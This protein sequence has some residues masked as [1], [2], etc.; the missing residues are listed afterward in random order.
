M[1]Y[2]WYFASVHVLLEQFHKYKAS[3]IER[4]RRHAALEVVAEPSLHHWII[5]SCGA[6]YKYKLP[7]FTIIITTIIIRQRITS[8]TYCHH[9]WSLHSVYPLVSIPW[10]TLCIDALWKCKDP[11]F[12]PW[13]VNTKSFIVM[14]ANPGPPKKKKKKESVSLQRLTRASQW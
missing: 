4:S 5:C 2:M 9:R 14:W 12:M 6:Q 13:L 7:K 3:C 10:T 11:Q 1:C 8:V